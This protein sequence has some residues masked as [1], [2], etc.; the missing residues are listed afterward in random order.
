MFRN[1]N[2]YCLYPSKQA[3]RQEEKNSTCK[4]NFSEKNYKV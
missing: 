4:G 3:D 1:I 2:K